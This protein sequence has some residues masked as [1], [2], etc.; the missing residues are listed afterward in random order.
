MLQAEG[1]SGALGSRHMQAQ[2]LSLISSTSGS[3]LHEL[4]T[5]DQ[6]KYRVAMDSEDYT[7]GQERVCWPADGGCECIQYACVR[8]LLQG[9][10]D[11]FVSCA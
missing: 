2:P 5:Q 7:G 10:P 8:A 1:Q 9:I 3:A 4:Q 6:A 11:D